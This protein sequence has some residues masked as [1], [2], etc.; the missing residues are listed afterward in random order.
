MLIGRLFSTSPTYSSSPKQSVSEKSTA[1]EDRADT[2]YPTAASPWY[3]KLESLRRMVPKAQNK[4]LK[5]TA[6]KI[7][8]NKQV[9]KM[10]HDL[11]MELDQMLN[12]RGP[13]SGANW[14]LWAA[15]A[16]ERAGAVLRGQNPVMGLQGP[17]RAHLNNANGVARGDIGGPVSSFVE[18]FKNDEAPNPTKINKFLEG[19]PDDK[20]REV[21]DCYYNAMWE[22]DPQKKQELTLQGNIVYGGREQAR[23]DKFLNV[24]TCTLTPPPSLAP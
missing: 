1:P 10:F 5:V 22:D 23:L 8:R 7:E 2:S 15:H 24:P 3:G 14:G 6:E 21:F 19:L 16:S 17:G 11:G 12:K 4:S 18:T 20:L 9:T 13:K